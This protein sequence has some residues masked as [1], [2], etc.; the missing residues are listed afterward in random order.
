MRR[1]TSPLRTVA[2]DDPAV[3]DGSSEWVVLRVE[4]TRGERRLRVPLRRRNPLDDCL[5]DLFDPCPLLGGAGQGR[6]RI[7]PEFRIDL[8]HDPLHVGRRKIDLLMTG[9]ISRSCS[10]AMYRFATV[11]AWTPWTGVDQEED[12]PFAEARDRETS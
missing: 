1:T 2:L 4:D 6:V 7:K 3:D 11:C 9:M 8:F 5:H 10:M 12:P